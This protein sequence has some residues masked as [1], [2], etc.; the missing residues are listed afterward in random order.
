[1]LQP[2]PMHPTQK[3]FQGLPIHVFPDAQLPNLDGTHFPMIY[4][5]VKAGCTFVEHKALEF[6][7]S[8][9]ANFT[10]N[11]NTLRV[12]EGFDTMSTDTSAYVYGSFA[13]SATA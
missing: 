11:Q 12:I 6:A 1:M 5:S 7:A 2:N 8:E 9:H 4:G 10:K 3:M 13:A